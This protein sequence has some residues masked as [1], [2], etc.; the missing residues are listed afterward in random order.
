M[1]IHQHKLENWQHGHQFVADTQRSERR[2]RYVL[3]LTAVTMVIEII[4]GGLYGSMA[5]LA[6]G[7]HMATHV[8]AFAIAMFTYQYARKHAENPAF[9][10]GTAKVNV[11]GG[12]AS[13]MALLVVA[14][15]MVIESLQRVIEPQTILFN[16]AIFVATLGLIV[17]LISAVLL[18]HSHEHGHAHEHHHDHAHHHDHNLRA[19][20]IHVLTD[21][22]TSLLA[23]IALLVGKYAGWLW[24]DPVMGVVA[25]IIITRW[26]IDLIKQ[27]S[28]ILLDK[29]ES[30][31]LES[32]IRSQLL[33]DHHD[34]ICDFHLWRLSPDH[35]AVIISLV[36]KSDRT[37][38]DYKQRIQHTKKLSHITI[39]VNVWNDE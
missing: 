16:E 28:P 4:A 5:L 13:A 30:Q 34:Q 8:A 11:L 1:H 33:T 17:N 6:D 38:E 14:L 21:A 37:P 15:V 39:E 35:Y 32:D 7:W 31:D 24:L 10:F 23:I 3:I 2:T 29:N 25:S 36:T 19:A 26:A 20:Y 9:S 12:F 22:L 18:D 27:T